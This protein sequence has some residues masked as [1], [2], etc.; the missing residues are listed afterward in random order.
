MSITANNKESLF[1]PKKLH[2]KWDIKQ[3]YRI[4]RTHSIVSAVQ[5]ETDTCR[6]LN[7]IPDPFFSERLWKTLFHL[8]DTFL[9]LPV[10]IS[11]ID[12]LHILEFPYHTPLKKL[13]RTEPL[14]LSQIIQL[15]SDL[16]ES[17]DT[18]HKAGILHMDISADNIFYHSDHRFILGDFSESCFLNTLSRSKKDPASYSR[19][20]ESICESPSIASEQYYLGILFYLL[21]NDGAAPPDTFCGNI[22]S[23]LPAL[24]ASPEIS[25]K[26]HSIL[27]K[28]LAQNPAGRYQELSLLRQDLES[29]ETSALK[30]SSYQLFLPDEFHSFHQTV[31]PVNKNPE[32][33]K[34]K[35]RI[36]SIPF[37]VLV[38]LIVTGGMLIRLTGSIFN[39]P[40]KYSR[41]DVPAASISTETALTIPQQKQET[42]NTQ[43]SILDIANRSLSSLLTVYSEGIH[44]K[45]IQILLAENNQF[46]DATD[47]SSLS[48]LQEVYLSSNQITDTKSFANLTNLKILIL[49]DNQC[50]TVSGLSTL[51]QLEFLDLSGNHALTEIQELQNLKKLRTLILSDTA[52]S[53][54]NIQD[55]QQSLPECTI[56]Y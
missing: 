7:I 30:K 23:D 4:T 27:S 12:D 20:S 39:R 35:D 17:L 51:D 37:L 8:S 29:L 18:L 34:H 1:L 31:T 22:P 41:N 50:T 24:Q 42:E 48:A 56:I 38:I 32:T 3:Y 43:N 10:K 46:T 15:I 33:S 52:V 47:L 9:L 5:R 14:P 55:L 45:S 25:E 11:L 16:T 13:V 2:E 36:F 53:L 6:I 44:P 21:C 26:L 54:D 49:S 19:I 40:H 28:M